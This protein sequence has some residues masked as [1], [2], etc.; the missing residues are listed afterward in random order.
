MNSRAHPRL[1]TP[2]SSLTTSAPKVFGCKGQIIHSQGCF[3]VC[4]L[5]FSKK[6]LRDS[7]PSPW[8]DAIPVPADEESTWNSAGSGSPTQR[9]IPIKYLLCR[10]SLSEQPQGIRQKPCAFKRIWQSLLKEKPGLMNKKCFL[11]GEAAL[12]TWNISKWYQN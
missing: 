12:K 8:A 4:F 11:L 5:L 2:N 1:A 7:F 10:S 3:L 6:F 9:I